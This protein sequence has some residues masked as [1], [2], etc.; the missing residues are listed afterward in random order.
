MS[1]L[2]LEQVKVITLGSDCSGLGSDFVALKLAFGP[3]IRLKTKF[4]AEPGETNPM[5]VMRHRTSFTRTF[6]TGT[7]TQPPGVDIFVSGTPC[8]PF[9]SAGLRKSLQDKRG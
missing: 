1:I 6:G 3:D 8:P 4:M 5:S 9:S 2:F 7:T